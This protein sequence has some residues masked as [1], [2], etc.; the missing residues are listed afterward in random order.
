MGHGH[1]V[2]LASKAAMGKSDG[3]A[4]APPAAREWEKI[5]IPAAGP[6]ARPDLTNEL[7]TPGAGC[8]ASLTVCSRGDE[9]DSAAG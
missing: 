4:A 7:A 5:P 6:H 3:K 2:R 1:K 9:V 8:L